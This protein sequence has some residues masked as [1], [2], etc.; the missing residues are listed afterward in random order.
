MIYTI[1]Y[2]VTKARLINYLVYKSRS[3]LTSSNILR[4]S[5]KA[6]TLAAI[7]LELGQETTTSKAYTKASSIIEPL[8]EVNIVAPPPPYNT[9]PIVNKKSILD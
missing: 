2:I 9:I 4:A 3:L 7:G 8:V 1:K 6:E 5:S